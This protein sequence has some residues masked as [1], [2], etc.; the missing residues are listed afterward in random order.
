MQDELSDLHRQVL[1]TFGQPVTIISDTGSLDSTGIISRELIPTGLNDGVLQEVTVMSL[2]SQ[3][4]IKRGIKITS[5][6]QQWTVDR[7]LKDDGHL[8][9]WSIHETRP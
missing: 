6:S 3:L 9:Y 8:A 5:A 2:D 1:A 4:A 7:K